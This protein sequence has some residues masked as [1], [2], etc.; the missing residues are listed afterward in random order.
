M[1]HGTLS[2][3]AG[4]APSAIAGAAPSAPP[5]RH[6]YLVFKD[7]NGVDHYVPFAPDR[8]TKSCLAET[9]PCSVMEKELGSFGLDRFVAVMLPV[10]E[11]EAGPSSASNVEFCG[12]A[13]LMASQSFSASTTVGDAVWDTVWGPDKEEAEDARRRLEPV[14]SLL[15]VDPLENENAV[16]SSVTHLAWAGLHAFPVVNSPEG[17]VWPDTDAAHRYVMQQATGNAALSYNFTTKTGT[18]TMGAGSPFPGVDV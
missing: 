3:I 8:E 11:T 16:W 2:A 5:E 18:F 1:N 12:W 4:A 6:H 7:P 9:S 15:R 10:Y 13:T 17:R 14:F